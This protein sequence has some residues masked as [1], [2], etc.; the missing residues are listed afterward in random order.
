[1]KHPPAWLAVGIWVLVF[2]L[3]IA[4]MGQ[5]KTAPTPEPEPPALGTVINVYGAKVE[6][7]SSEGVR[8]EAVGMGADGRL[9]FGLSTGKGDVFSILPSGEVEEPPEASCK[10]FSLPEPRRECEG[11]GYTL[12]ITWPGTPEP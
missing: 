2:I 10:N 11:R 8:I 12:T 4:M 9:N 7:A 5:E 1:M 6:I 3:A